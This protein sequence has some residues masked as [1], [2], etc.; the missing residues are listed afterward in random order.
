[1][2]I[3]NKCKQE[4]NL[5]CFYQ[6]KGY[7]D[8][9]RPVCKECCRGDWRSWYSLNKEERKA[10]C[11]EWNKNN[12]DKMKAKS[13][14]WNNRNRLKNREAFLKRK[15]NMTLEDYDILLQKQD[16]KC[17]ICKIDALDLGKLLYVDHCHSTGKVRGLLCP[18]CNSGIGLLKESTEILESAIKYLKGSV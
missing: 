6:G 8:G 10:T 4:K 13:K 3:C 18:T 1:M 15:F 7:K 9:V 16:S 2:K 14:K 5:D 12:P 17:K 11:R